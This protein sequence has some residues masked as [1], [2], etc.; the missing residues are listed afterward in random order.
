MIPAEGA[1]ASGMTELFLLWA[2]GINFA[3]NTLLG[4]KVAGWRKFFT[5]GVSF[6]T[7]GTLPV[8]TVLVVSTFHVIVALRD[9]NII[10]ANW[11]VPIAVGV[12]S[13][14]YTESLGLVTYSVRAVP[15]N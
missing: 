15:V 8:F 7:R 2:I 4:V 11:F 10:C 6:A 3:L 5:V 14:L 1:T 13:A 12:S 9:A